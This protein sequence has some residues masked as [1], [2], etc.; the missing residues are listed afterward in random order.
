MTLFGKPQQKHKKQ[1]G[2]F[3]ITFASKNI[4]EKHFESK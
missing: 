3:L 1:R 4:K 2:H